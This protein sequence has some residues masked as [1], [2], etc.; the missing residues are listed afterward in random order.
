MP[1]SLRHAL[2]SLKRTPAFTAAAILTLV[3]G[4]G[5]VAATFAIVYGVLLEPLPYGHPD[6]LVSIGLGSPELRRIEQPPAVYFTYKRFARR[7]DDIGFY[8]T[9]N[10]NIWTLDAGDAPE[11]VTATWVTT[12]TIPLL[13]VAPILGRS[14]DA[15]SKPGVEVNDISSEVNDYQWRWL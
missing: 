10:A 9:G 4:I 15:G 13:Q 11:R 3:L 7:I 1:T 5:S 2:R 6:R 8:R 14:G 12:S